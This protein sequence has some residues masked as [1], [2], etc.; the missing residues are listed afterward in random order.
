MKLLKY[1][2]VLVSCAAVFWFVGYKVS[3]NALAYKMIQENHLTSPE[4]VFKYVI[5]HKI[6]AP[7]G[8]PNSA[9]GASFRTLVNRPGDWLWCDEGAIVVAVMVGNLGYDTRLVDL[10]GTRDGVSHH[11]VLQ[12][13]QADNWVTYDFTGR[14]F[15][16]SL[17]KTVDYPAM[18]IYRPYPN[19]QQKLLLN[20]YFLRELAQVV[21]PWLI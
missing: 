19:W 18:P 3:D 15:N 11:T 4:Q 12:I 16:V 13:Q 8:S 1:F 20:N 9:A 14:Q 10:V 17:D 5:D 7:S 21:R 2:L 6:Q